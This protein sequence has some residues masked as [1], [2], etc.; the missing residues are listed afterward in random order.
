MLLEGTH[1]RP[2]DPP[3]A[4]GW[5]ALACSVSD[6]AAMA[7]VPLAATV[8]LG[9]RRGVTDRWIRGFVSGMLRC[10]RAYDCPV[11]GG[12]TTSGTGPVAI[13]VAV[14]GRAD[15]PVLRSGARAFDAI[16]VTGTLGGSILGKHLRFRPRLSEAQTLAR[17]FPLHAM[18]DISDGLSLD[19]SRLCDESGAG[20]ILEEAA[21][22]VS[23]AARTLAAKDGLSP[24]S[25]A[26]SDGEDFELLFTMP[27]PAARRLLAKNPLGIRVS[28]VGT[29]VRERGLRLRR[30]DGRTVRL[31]P[32]GYVHRT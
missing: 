11:V 18:M 17:R 23:T 25:H 14:L 6:V 2:T 22:P 21:I 20:A 16:L 28:R 12:D 10:A 3:A 5:K 4:V 15:R 26:L 19:L 8:S 31:K 32:S 27:E 7:A 29:I 9:L 24:L 13:D 1:F 30:R